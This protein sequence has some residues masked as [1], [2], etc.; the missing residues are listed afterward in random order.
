VSMAGRPGRLRALVALPLAASLVV[1]LIVPSCA[2]EV[3]PTDRAAKAAGKELGSDCCQISGER[4]PHPLVQVP[5]PDPAIA[6]V[7]S[8]ADLPA[9]GLVRLLAATGPAAAPAVLQGVGVSTLFVS[10]PN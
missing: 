3:C 8:A 2:D 6:A 10:V 1:A 4:V 9:P 7:T 5:P